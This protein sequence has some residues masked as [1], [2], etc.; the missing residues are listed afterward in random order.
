L[1]VTGVGLDDGLDGI[2]SRDVGCGVI[3]AFDACALDSVGL[4]VTSVGLRVA[5]SGL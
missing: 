3:R 5:G 4:R 2:G 1:C